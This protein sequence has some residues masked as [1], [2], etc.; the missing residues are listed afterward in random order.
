MVLVLSLPMA[1][2]VTNVGTLVRLRI[3]VLVSIV[4]MPLAFARLPHS[5]RDDQDRSAR[6]PTTD[7]SSATAVTSGV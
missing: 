6:P 3:M 4:T 7:A 2:V 1:Y 5:F